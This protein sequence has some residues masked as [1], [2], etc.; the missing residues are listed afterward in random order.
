MLENV[1]YFGWIAMRPK[2]LFKVLFITAAALARGSQDSP[3]RL[4]FDV[5][6]IHSSP[7]D[8]AGG[9]IRPLPNGSGYT[10]QNMTVRTM[11]ALMYR[12]PEKQ[13]EGAPEWFG[14]E[15]FNV[16]ARADRGG[17]TIDELHTMFKSLLADRFGLK[18][19]VETREGPVYVLT[20]A[21][22]GTK[23]KADGAVGDLNIPMTPQGPGQ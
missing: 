18:F 1:S 3:Q 17:Y 7:P 15:R 6:A 14:T 22:G 9:I 12:I 23:M 8:A 4:T 20:V 16:E 5:V 19:H 2:F 21:K 11:M 10:A 13:I